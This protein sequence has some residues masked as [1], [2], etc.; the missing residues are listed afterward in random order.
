MP[1]ASLSSEYAED[2]HYTR[3]RREEKKWLISS[4]RLLGV[5]HRLHL[6]RQA[7]KSSHFFSSQE[8]SR[9]NSMPHYLTRLLNFQG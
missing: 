6:V 4:L 9:S 3:A 8:D 1:L 5:A 7:L 2:R